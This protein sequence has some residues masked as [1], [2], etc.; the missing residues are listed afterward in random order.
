MNKLEVIEQGWVACAGDQIVAVGTADS[1]Q[2]QVEI[3][4]ATE[5]IDATDQVVAPGLIDPHTHLIFGGSREDEFYL[6]AQGADYMK[7]MEAGGG[8]ASSVRSTRA[9]SLEELV[10]AGKQRLN[11]MLEMG[12]TTVECKSGYGLDLE[13]E[14]RQ[15]E[16]VR[17][18]Q[19]QQ[20]VE[21]VSTFLGAHAWPE[22]YADD[23]EGYVDF[24]IS[25]VLPKVKEENLAEFV[26]VFTEKGVFS[27]EQSRRI[28]L[29]A[30]ELGFKLRI[31][32]DEMHNLG[33]AELAAEL[34]TASADH[35]LMISEQG[36]KALAAS[37]VIPILLPATAFTLRKPYAPARKML[38]ANLPI[39]LATDFNPGSCPTANLA[40]VMSLACLYMAM[41]P[42]EVFHAVTINAAHSLGRSDRLGSIEVGKQADLVIFA[43]NSYKKVPYFIGVNLV[44]TVVKAGELV[45]RK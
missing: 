20:P 21:L 5:V 34:G 38:A 45:I 1:V 26:D 40:L 44:T 42:E 28:F 11:W 17:V 35:L 7:I 13:T 22:E 37:D 4:E 12:V 2:N 31:H 41:T 23:R 6:R 10:A 3:T 43:V 24:L 16:A 33:G 14:L 36:I 30:Q 19:G 32:A 8:I 15:L 25:S 39:A 18:L 29:R 9:T 27:V